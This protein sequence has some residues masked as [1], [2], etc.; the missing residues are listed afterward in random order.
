MHQIHEKSTILNE[1]IAHGEIAL[2]GGMYDVE[3]GLV[4]FY[5][6]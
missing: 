2:I 1:M 6:E 3:T 4:D 5:E